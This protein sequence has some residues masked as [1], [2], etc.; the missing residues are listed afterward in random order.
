MQG[1]NRRNYYRVLQVQPDASLS[2]IKNNYRTLMQTLRMHPDL[3]GVS[4]DASMLNQAYSVLRNPETRAAYD[5]ELLQTM[6]VA[7]LSR[8]HFS[9]SDLAGTQPRE[10]S[11]TRRGNRRNYYRVLQVQTDAPQAI[12]DAS[13]RKLMADAALPGDLLDEAY[14]VLGDAAKRMAYDR[15][16]SRSAAE[17]P[18]DQNNRSTPYP[19][20]VTCRCVF[21]HAANAQCEYGE[22]YDLC[23]E[24]GSPLFSPPRQFVEQPRRQ[25]S[26]T[27]QFGS[28]ILYTAWPGE[29]LHA[30]LTDLSPTGLKFETRHPLNEQQTLKIDGEFFCAVG[31]VTYRQQAM[32]KTT[33]GV[34]FLTIHFNRSKGCFVADTV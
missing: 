27:E 1:D 3:G 12:I 29:Q 8:G 19:S 10:G 17:P 7:T 18:G 21:C 28:L 25:L 30:N 33:A 34:Q 15:A 26:R 20:L 24:C 9:R 11:A 6:D 32:G 2:V 14:G 13:Y 4:G 31:R 23:T 16:L 22:S 5:R